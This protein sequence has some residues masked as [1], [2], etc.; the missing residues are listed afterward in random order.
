[1]M[2]TR[3]LSPVVAA[4][5]VAVFALSA[6]AVADPFAVRFP[7][8]DVLLLPVGAEDGLRHPP[9]GPEDPRVEPSRGELYD[10][11]G[12]VIGRFT[13]V[14][15]DD[16][17]AVAR[18]DALVDGRGIDDLH[19]A[20]LPDEGLDHVVP[21]V[22]RNG[23]YVELEAGWSSGDDRLRHGAKGSLQVA[24]GEVGALFT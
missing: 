3:R 19:H 12:A 1:M 6:T 11:S 22:D 21:R 20:A 15:A 10:A 2:V 4:L 14:W 16:L 7:V 9:Q 8:G 24:T 17:D 5:V 23:R 13:V 18:V